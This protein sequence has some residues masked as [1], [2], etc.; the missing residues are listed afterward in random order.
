MRYSVAIPSYRRAE[1]LRDYTL[2]ALQAAGMP[3]HKISVFVADD[4][5]FEH[6]TQILQPGTYGMLVLAEPGMRAMREFIRYHYLDGLPLVCCD[7][8]IQGF[9]KKV[10]D[11]TYVPVTDL[12]LEI[13]RAFEA[14]YQYD[15]KLWGIYPVL[16]AM[17][18]RHTVTTDLRYIVGCFWG[19]INTHDPNMSVTLDDKEDFE[20]TL[21]F[22]IRDGGVVRLN[23]LAPK[24][25]YYDQPG[26]MQVLRTPE[27]V[28]ASALN[29]YKRYPEY[30]TLNTKK[31][32]GHVELRLR[33]R[34]RLQVRRSKV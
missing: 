14:C 6:Y 27:R 30:C 22:Y 28:A 1:T 24:T 16:N 17:F 34:S 33:D 11:K 15:C 2:P 5:Q 29:L 21:K 4:E 7:D 26:G 20:R 25:R 10:D 12:Q 32:S 23:D 9:Y 3:Y 31:K 18:M 13:H 8:D 19:C